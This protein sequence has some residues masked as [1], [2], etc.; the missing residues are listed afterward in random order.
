MDFDRKTI[1][2]FILIGL[3]FLL[4]NTSYYQKTF[5]PEAYKAK[6]QREQL[7]KQYGT[8]PE[9]EPEKNVAPLRTPKVKKVEPV[10]SKPQ[11][12]QSLQELL[13]SESD[14]KIPEKLYNIETPLYKATFSSKGG[15]L[16]QFQLKKYEGPDG[17][18][19]R[20][21]PAK[22]VG[23][24]VISFVTPE[25]DTLDTSF[26]NFQ[27]SN[28]SLI[29]LT[30]NK[31]QSKLTF[32]VNFKGGQSI[33]KEFVFYNNT[34][35]FDMDVSLLRMGNLIGDKAY[36]VRA[37]S[38][39][40]STEKRLKDDMQY[41][42][43]L[44]SAGDEVVK[45]GKTNGKV[46]KETGQI[47]W[48]AVRTKYFALVIIPVSNKGMYAEVKG[49]EIPVDP[50]NKTSLKK[51]AISLT[52]PFINQNNQTDKF[53][54]YVGPLDYDIVKKYGVGLEKI[55]DFGFFLIQPFS[56]A[57]LWSF[58]KLHGIIPNYG[59]VLIIF[60]IMI[61]L[62]VYPLTHKSYESMRRMQELQPKLAELKEKY[63]KDPQRLN[64]ETMKL[65][66]EEG[67]NPMGGCLP[68]LLQMPLLWG[69]FIVFR[70]TIELRGAGFIWWIKDL[71]MPDTVAHLPF[72]IPI[73][74][75]S[76][77]ILPLLMGATMLV[78]QKLTVTDPK[79]K[80]MVYFMPLFMTLLFNQF[81]SGLNLYYTLFNLLSIIQQKWLVPMHKKEAAPVM[82]DVVRKRKK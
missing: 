19:V 62:I 47:N 61:K 44:I 53:M 24:L 71:S 36:F 38:G 6:Q 82:A 49:E 42:K 52:M 32:Q 72:T 74:G 34:Y 9:R 10:A 73:Y 59:L 60:S 39:L 16:V 75:D 43:A 55:M 20:M 48:V 31:D 25:G 78:Q 29:K 41:S 8:E 40:A 81:P 26:L 66:K 64:K 14:S 37:P 21:F 15:A 28:D 33:V 69:L 51:F 57:I 70:S 80:A 65:Y 77:N 22:A 18:S 2:A 67:V 56:K 11:Q 27:S 45:K 5:F 63:S 4:I 68:M 79:Q 35:H 46:F 7:A 3:I 23:D 1:L 58:K 76:V 50:K 30:Q 54:V 13:L 17:Q 12:N